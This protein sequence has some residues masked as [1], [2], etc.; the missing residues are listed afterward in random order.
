ML[1][2]RDIAIFVHVA[3]LQRSGHE[4]DAAIIQFGG[5]G[6]SCIAS[7]LRSRCN[8]HARYR[9]QDFFLPSMFN[10]MPSGLGILINT[11]SLN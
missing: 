11:N 9:V 4:R 7:K 1:P 10:L 6:A 8:R 5:L 3:R 2:N